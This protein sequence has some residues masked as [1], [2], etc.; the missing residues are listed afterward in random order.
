MLIY[1]TNLAANIEVYSESCQISKFKYFSYIVDSF[2]VLT[3]FEK[4]SILDFWQVLSTPL[5]AYEKSF[6]Q[7]TVSSYSHHKSFFNSF[8]MEVFIILNQSINLQSKSVDWFLYVSDFRHERVK[9]AASKLQFNVKFEKIL[10]GY[11]YEKRDGIKHGTVR[12]FHRLYVKIFSICDGITR[13]F[14]L[15]FVLPF[16]TDELHKWFHNFPLLEEIVDKTTLPKPILKFN[17]SFLVLFINFI[18]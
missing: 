13:N 6:T 4:S 2:Q 3:I 17:S 1:E 11:L 18:C 9:Y 14:G 7:P 10:W 15:N 12:F 8:M 16:F 5:D